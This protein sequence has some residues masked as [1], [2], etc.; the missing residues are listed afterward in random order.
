[1][2][3]LS[4]AQAVAI[5]RAGLADVLAGPGQG[6]WEIRTGSKIGVVVGD[7]WEL[8]VTPRI[9]VPRL[10]FLL[11][12]AQDQRGWKKIT[13]Q[14][15]REDD[16]FGAIAS[17]FSWHATWALDR[18]LLRGYVGRE[19]RRNDIRGRVLFGAQIAR[20]GGLPLPIHVAYDDFTAD[21]LENRMLR[22]ATQLLLRLPRIPAE[23]RKRLLRVRAVLEGVSPLVAWRGV[24]A[25]ETTRLNE[26][27][28]AALR[29]AELVL[30][31]ASVNA[32]VGD[33]RSTTF[34]F[35]MNKV[36]EDFLTAAF[37]EAMR[38][39][40]GEVRSQIAP[41]SLDE[42]GVLALKPDISW[43]IGS[44]CAAIVDAKY[45]AVDDGVMKHPD[46]Y[47]MLAYCLSYGLQTGY[48]A[49]AKDSGQEARTHRIRHSENDIVV[50]TIDVEKEP[51]DVL[52]D[53]AA[54]AS[55]IAREVR[56]ARLAA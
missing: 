56:S 49:Y 25:P 45:K 4:S 27:Y 53:V 23:A 12:Y 24:A 10:M 54:L 30:A 46:A 51:E 35:D 26:R 22:T 55:R 3:Q 41:Y 18:G 52:A 29:L 17:G 44:S 31:G 15:G 6:F 16:L 14:F 42:S 37:R 40:G 50:A 39:H 43:W 5:E 19:E 2:R 33:V 9:D 13:A 32:A 28:E 38:P 11:A 36:F 7:D 34:V 8:R 21:V 48:L 47:Q 1:M 20:S